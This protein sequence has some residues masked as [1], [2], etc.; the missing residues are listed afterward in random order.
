MV[1][2]SGCSVECWA[3]TA[4]PLLSPTARGTVSRRLPF[5]SDGGFD[6]KIKMHLIVSAGWEF[7]LE[8][9]IFLSFAPC[10]H[11]ERLFVYTVRAD[12]GRSVGRS[13]A[14]SERMQMDK[15]LALMHLLARILVCQRR[16]RLVNTAFD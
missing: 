12:D 5:H 4:P 11:T 6:F 15:F 14:H 9:R 7:R 8:T 16:R 3:P 13:G 2:Q 1:G 10:S